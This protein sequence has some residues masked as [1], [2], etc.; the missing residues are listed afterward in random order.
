MLHPW[1]SCDMRMRRRCGEGADANIASA[2]LAK[3][4]IP[5]IF[6]SL[7]ARPRMMFSIVMKQG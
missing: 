2:Y 6:E 3:S 7:H 4:A 5:F 1:M